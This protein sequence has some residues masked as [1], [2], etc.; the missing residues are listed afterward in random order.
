MITGNCSAEVARRDPGTISHSRWITTANRI[1]RLYV[2]TDEPSEAL[3]ILV[4]YITKVYAPVW[5]S[6]KCSSSCKDGLRHL[7][8]LVHL[9]R[10]LPD[11]LKAVTDP[12]IQRNGYF[13]HPENMLLALITDSSHHM[14]KL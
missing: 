10:Y 13:A 7:W 2:S 3:Q 5:L 12:A 14:R 4:M 8:K 1:L 9:S 6:I 11:N